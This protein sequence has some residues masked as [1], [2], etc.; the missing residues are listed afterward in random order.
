MTK[1]HFIKIA[2]TIKDQ[3]EG[4]KSVEERATV[5][6]VVEALMDDFASF[7]PNFDY[8]VFRAACGVN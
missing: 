7:N 4:C 8:N 2:A 1:K 5:V 3:L 6:R